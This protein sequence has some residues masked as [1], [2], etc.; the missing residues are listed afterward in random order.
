MAGTGWQSTDLLS[1][2][3]SWAQLPAS[4]GPISDANLYQRLS[5]AQ[6]QVILEC[7]NLMGRILFTP[8]FQ[9]TSSDGGYT[10]GYGNDGNGYALFPL[11]GYVYPTEQAIPG[12]PWVPQRDYLDEGTVIRGLYNTVIPLAPWFYGI[13]QPAQL[14][15]STQPVIQ[16]TPSRV[17][18][19]IEAV[20]LYAQEGNRDQ[21]LAA[22]M[23]VR[24]D[25]QW[26]RWATAIRRHLRGPRSLGPL[27][28][29]GGTWTG[30]GI[31]VGGGG[32]SW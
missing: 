25:E 9:M 16:P 10:Y 21:N 17:L 12:Y 23:Q 27:T 30:A 4:N 22:A 15:A 14:S 13:V 31:G 32:S 29:G 8:P 3:Q 20:K 2:F 6:D 24:W 7:A 19:V 18:I 1:R 11:A 26:P 28:A 5:D